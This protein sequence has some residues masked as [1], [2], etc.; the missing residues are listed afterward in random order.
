MLE[1][2]R[3]VYD[4]LQAKVFAEGLFSKP[5]EVKAGVRAPILFAL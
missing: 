1:T 5:F 2:I 4:G 3:G